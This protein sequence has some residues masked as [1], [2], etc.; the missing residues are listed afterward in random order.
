MQHNYT[1]QRQGRDFSLLEEV[2][3]LKN[4]EMS[5]E[6]NYNN[7]DGILG[8]NDP[9][10]GSPSSVADW[11]GKDDFEAKTML[12]QLEYYKAQA[13]RNAVPVDGR[14]PSPERGL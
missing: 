4:A 10:P 5:I 12:E 14:E 1:R 7:I 3:H 13:E 8:N 11:G 6:G 2:N 9:K